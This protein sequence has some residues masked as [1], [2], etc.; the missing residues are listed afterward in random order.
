MHCSRRWRRFLPHSYFKNVGEEKVLPHSYFKNVGEEKVL[1]H[2]YFKNVGD[3]FLQY[4]TLRAS[5]EM[6]QHRQTY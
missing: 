4:Y 3:D 5:L 1:P 2:S 6:G